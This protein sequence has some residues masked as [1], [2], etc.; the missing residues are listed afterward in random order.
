[1][2]AAGY[3]YVLD[4]VVKVVGI[5]GKLAGT[6]GLGVKHQPRKAR[7]KLVVAMQIAAVAFFKLRGAQFEIEIQHF[8]CR[9]AAANTG[10]GYA[11]AQAI[12]YLHGK[13]GFA[14]VGIG[15]H[16]A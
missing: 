4:S 13:D 7:A 10:D 14:Y 8:L 2:G 16:N 12:A 15:K 9:S 1:M 3:Q 6:I 11:T 5:G